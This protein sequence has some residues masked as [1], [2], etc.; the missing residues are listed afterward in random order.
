M[1]LEA[2][3]TIFWWE[4]SHRLLGRVIGAVVLLPLVFFWVTGRLEAALKPRVVTI[5]L[6]G[7]LQGAVGWWM[8]V[9]GLSERTDVSQYRLAAHLTLACA[10]LAYVWWVARSIAPSYTP[11]VPA[12]RRGAA[13]IIALTL[14][15][16]F[17]GGL[18]AGVNAGYTFNTWPLMDGTWI[19]SGLLALEPWW[20]NF[21]ENVLTVQFEHRLGAYVLLAASLIY[22]YLARRTPQASGAWMLAGLVLLQ[23]AIGVAT[24]VAVVPVPLGLL[25]QFCAVVVLSYAVTHL[26]SMLRPL[27]IVA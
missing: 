8:V 11:S 13:I 14:V 7:A 3:K 15:Q 12:T 6:L 18:V 5:F 22:A 4:W 26:R 20:R 24:L 23:A 19:P 27:P 17:I 25:H 10:I 16:I 9:S 21:F 1:S 2:F